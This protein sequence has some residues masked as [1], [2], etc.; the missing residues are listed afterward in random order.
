L[1]ASSAPPVLINCLYEQLLF[2][3]AK[4]CGLLRNDVKALMALSVFG[5]INRNRIIKMSGLHHQSMYPIFERLLDK[6]YV[7]T[8]NNR[9]KGIH[10]SEAGKQIVNGANQLW[11]DIVRK[12]A[13]RMDMK[14]R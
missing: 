6:G 8:D 2:E 5:G 11:F 10:L 1:G 9:P 3:Y 7:N 13:K 14:L 4:G 12:G